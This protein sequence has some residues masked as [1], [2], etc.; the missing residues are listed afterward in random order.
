MLSAQGVELREKDNGY[1][2]GLCIFILHLDSSSL[3]SRK[4]SPPAWWWNIRGIMSSAIN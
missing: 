2:W 3:S 1:K 4:K